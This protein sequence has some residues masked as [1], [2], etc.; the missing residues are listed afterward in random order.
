ME[1]LEPAYRYRGRQAAFVRDSLEGA[2]TLHVVGDIDL[3]N[4]AEFEAA[5][6]KMT[7]STGPRVI[8]LTCCTYID[9]TAVHVL[10]RTSKR[11]QF[12]VLAAVGGVVQR[13]FTI[14]NAAA[15]L[16]IDYKVV[17]SIHANRNGAR[18]PTGSPT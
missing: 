11:L 10:S 15:L 16:S 3:A 17:P 8:D 12:S 14:A 6:M 7:P 18:P 1:N 9:S 2:E 13:I 4:A 5:I